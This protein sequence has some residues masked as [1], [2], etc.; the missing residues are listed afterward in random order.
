MT[1]TKNDTTS[2]RIDRGGS[3]VSYIGPPWVRAACRSTNVP[4]YRGRNFGFRTSLPHRQPVTHTR[5]RTHT[6]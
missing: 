5:E 1:P 4:A 2:P 3:W 6:A